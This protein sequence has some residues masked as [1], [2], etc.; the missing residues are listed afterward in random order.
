MQFG[1]IGR[2]LGHSYSPEI[3][4]R[5]HGHDYQLVPM[6]PQQLPA[7]FARRDFAG[8]NVT[9]PYKVEAFHACDALGETARRAGCVNTIVKRP[10][11]TL[12][13][14]NTD[15]AG[16][17]F[18]LRRA[19]IDL[20][21]KHVLI[22]GA[23]GASQTVQ[24]ACADAQAASVTIADKDDSKHC[25][26]AEVLI[27][28]S[29]VGMYPHA[30]NTPVDLRDYPNLR[31]VADLIYNPSRTRLLQQ[32][33]KLG[34]VCINGLS[35]L[36]A[37]AAAAAELFLQQKIADEHAAQVLHSLN[38]DLQNWVL[39]GMPGCGKST[40][41]LDLAQRSGRSFVDIDHEIAQRTGTTPADIIRQQGE[42]AFRDIESQVITD[43]SAQTGLVIATGGG[44]VLRESNRQALRQNARVLWIQRAN[45]NLAR[46]GRPLSVDLDDLYRTR[47]PAYQDAADVAITH[48][49]DWDAVK[50]A[51]WAAFLSPCCALR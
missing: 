42:P 16:F 43:L 45:A 14:D 20:T 25:P 15:L 28:T 35:M 46:D 33:E 36:V 13:G 9:I 30:D 4:K 22:L 26:Q 1:L 44:A 24:L 8:I 27:N 40:I 41:G 34:L 50:Q 39:V 49:E 12:F 10:D 3:H 19:G 2:H 31:A 38:A 7:F 23:G 48:N 51:A 6:E 21:G 29:P 32:A 18:M 17:Q 5:L 47:E 37:Q 11:G